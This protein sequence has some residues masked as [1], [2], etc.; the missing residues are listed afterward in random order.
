M[1]FRSP[2]RLQEADILVIAH[3]VVS[4]A[5]GRVRRLA[6]VEPGESALELSRA[7]G[8]DPRHVQVVLDETR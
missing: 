7:G 1:L 6:E 4:K 5:E 2:E 3:K 8:R